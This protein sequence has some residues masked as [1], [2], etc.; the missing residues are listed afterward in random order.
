MALAK[1]TP[2]LAVGLH[3][4]LTL[5][6]PALPRNEIPDLVDDEGRLPSSATWA[7]LRFYF[8]ARVR[9]Q[10]EREIRAQI[11]EFLATGLPL[12]HLNGHQHLHMHPS[13]FPILAGCMDAYKIPAVRLVRDSLRMSLRLGAGRLGYKLSHAFFFSRLDRACRKRLSQTRC[14]AADRVFGLLEDGRMTRDHLLALVRELPD[15]AS[16]IYSHPSVSPGPDP[17]RLPLLEF[18]ALID[19]ALKELIRTLAID[20]TTYSRLATSK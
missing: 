5:S 16:E 1:E 2:S 17:T 11:E 15:G 3:L 9:T 12:D 8:S 6:W 20:L 18:E 7:G 19:P 10:L 4:A 13:V 14:V